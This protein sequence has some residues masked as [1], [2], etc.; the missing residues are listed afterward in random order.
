VISII[1]VSVMIAGRHPLI[2]AVR[3]DYS[4]LKGSRRALDFFFLAREPIGRPD[5]VESP[6]EIL[7]LLLP[8]PVSI[9]CGV[10]GMIGSS[11]TLD[12]Y[13]RAGGTGSGSSS[14]NDSTLGHN[15][16]TAREKMPLEVTP[17]FPRLTRYG[18][19]VDQTAPG[20]AAKSAPS[21]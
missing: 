5:S 21:N 10:A 14:A 19:I 13:A 16:T 1:P 7:K 3:E 15:M 9:S 18:A 4:I 2:C 6:S 8:Q 11:I 20:N 17:F 12:C